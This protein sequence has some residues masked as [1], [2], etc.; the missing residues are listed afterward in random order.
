MKGRAL[1]SLGGLAGVLVISAA[2]PHALA[3]QAKH[4]GT[5]KASSE[6]FETALAKVMAAAEDNFRPITGNPTNGG[7][8]PEYYARVALPGFRCRIV[9]GDDN[10]Y[11]RA[12]GEQPTKLYY[13]C[14]L[15][16]GYFTPSMERAYEDLVE[17]VKREGQNGNEVT[18][19]PR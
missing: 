19:P 6:S 17:K 2:I 14:V 7:P 12:K 8:P 10:W 5:V 4:G 1:F 18:G 15:V 16:S 3:Q 13:T 11:T 9:D